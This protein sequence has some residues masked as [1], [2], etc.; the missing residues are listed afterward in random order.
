[1]NLIVKNVEIVASLYAANFCARLKARAD[2]SL[3]KSDYVVTVHVNNFA[4]VHAVDFL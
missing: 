3:L 4:C 2:Y 1:M